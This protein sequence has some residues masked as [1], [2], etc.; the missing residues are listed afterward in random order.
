MWRFILIIDKYY[1]ETKNIKKAVIK[2]KIS[3]NVL[4]L[5]RI[6]KKKKKTDDW[7]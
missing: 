6:I 7:V 1:E 3:F 5:G 4:F 2:K